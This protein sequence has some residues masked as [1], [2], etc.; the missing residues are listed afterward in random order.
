MPP[1]RRWP[2]V[3]AALVLAGALAI[4]VRHPVRTTPVRAAIAGLATAGS[5][6]TLLA[7]FSGRRQRLTVAVASAALAVSAVAALAGL[8]VA[9]SYRSDERRDAA[10]CERRYSSRSSSMSERR[11]SASG[12]SLDS[13]PRRRSASRHSPRTTCSSRGAAD[14]SSIVV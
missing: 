9:P 11:R 6:A 8:P 10:S 13:S 4:V 5:L 12:E 7:L 3:L 14:I 1:P 2:F